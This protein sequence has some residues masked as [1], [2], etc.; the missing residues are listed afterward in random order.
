MAPKALQPAAARPGFAF[1]SPEQQDILRQSDEALPE[2]AAEG[3]RLIRDIADFGYEP[4]TSWEDVKGAAGEFSE[5]GF[6]GWAGNLAANV[7]AFGFEQFLVSSPD[8]AAVAVNLPAYALARSGELARERAEADNR[9]DLNDTDFTVGLLTASL[10]AAAEKVGLDI[11]IRGLRGGDVPPG[12]E[13]VIDGVLKIGAGT[14][15]TAG[16]EAGVEAVQEAIEYIGT[17]AGTET[18]VDAAELVDTMLAGAVG[19]S[20][21]G[22]AFGAAGSTARV[23]ELPDATPPDGFEIVD[24]GLGVIPP[25]TQ[26]LPGEMS[27]AVR[28]QEDTDGGQERPGETRPAEEYAGAPLGDG[29][30][31]AASVQEGPEPVRDSYV[32]KGGPV[33]RAE[34]VQRDPAGAHAL[35]D[36]AGRLGLDPVEFAA[37]MSWESAGTMN[38]NVTGGDGGVYQGLIQFSPDNQ[39]RYGIRPG[40]TIAQQMGAIEQ[41]LIDRGFEPGEHDIRHAYSA[42][43]AGQASEAYWDRTDSNGTSVRNAAPR[44]K[45]GDH[46]ARAQQFL[47]D[48]LDGLPEGGVVVGDQAAPDRDRDRDRLIEEIDALEA[49]AALA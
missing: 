43:L 22:A 31:G 29:R 45:S 23:L 33:K 25:G 26:P 36:A 12:A 30:Q 34:R 32:P 16:K 35:V 19:G 28:F 27:D 21:P 2:A 9:E 3:A 44:F 4:N 15:G 6:L 24:D 10:T 41:Y 37:L 48:S 1:L 39:E 46:Y 14:L 49:E 8:M 5:R 11:L 7:G 20:V 40:M 47:G 42:I 38:P 13:S 17:R 18:G